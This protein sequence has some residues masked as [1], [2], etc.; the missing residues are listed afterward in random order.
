MK[1]A[2]ISIKRPV[3]ITMVT[4]ALLVFGIISYKRLPVD[5]FPNVEFP[6][7]SVFVVYPGADPETIESD[8]LKKIED[9]I[10]ILPGIKEIRSL[11]TTNFGQVIVRFELETDLN[12]AIQDIRDKIALI[13]KE[14][15]SDV[16]PPL[17]QKFDIGAEPIMTYILYG[18][19]SPEDLTEIGEKIKERLQQVEGVGDVEI[20]GKRK[21]EIQIL[22]DPEK[23]KAFGLTPLD[24]VQLIGANNIDI[25]GGHLTNESQEINIKF[26]GKVLNLEELLDIPLITVK[27]EYLGT[28]TVKLKDV[29]RVVDGIKEVRSRASYN[30]KEALALVIRK[31]SGTNAVKVAHNVIGLVKELN[32]TLPKGIELQLAINLTEF[33]EKSVHDVIFD[34]LFGAALAVIIISIFLR[35]VRATVISGLALPTSVIATFI[36]ISIM[37]FTL[38]LLVMMALSISIGMLIDDAI[39]VIENI[40]RHLEGGE[41]RKTASYKG[42]SE[43]GLAVMATTF[44]IVAVFVPVAFTKGVIG[45]FLY[46]FGLTVSFAVLV[47][48]FV[49]FTLTPMLSSR[50]LKLPSKNIITL[51]IERGLAWLDT[52]YRIIIKWSLNHRFITVSIGFLAFIIGMILL[53]NIKKDMIPKIDRSQFYIRVKTPPG[54]SLT[55]TFTLAQE[56]GKFVSQEKIVKGI[57][58]SAGSGV[59]EEQNR[60]TLL[61]NLVPKEERTISQHQFMEKIRNKLEKIKGAV[62]SVEDIGIMGESFGFTT[63]PIQYV[64]N[65]NDID[66]LEEVAFKIME[67]MKLTSGFVDVT[68]NIEK[69]QPEVMVRILRER[70]GDLNIIGAQAGQLL[71]IMIAGLVTSKYTEKGRDYDIRVGMDPKYK[72]DPY[73]LELLSIRSSKGQ[74]IDFSNI[75]QFVPSIGRSVINRF[76]RERQVT[77]FANLKGISM[78]EG[79]AKVREISKGLLPSDL[80]AK[81]VGMG[82]IMEESF[83]SLSFALLLAIIMLYMILASQFE[84]FIYPLVIMVSLPVAIIGTGFMLW[85]TNTTITVFTY[86]GIIML[87]GLVTK[88]AILLVDY[89]NQLRRQGISRNDALIRAGGIRLRPILM[90]TLAMIFGML[91]V[92]LGKGGAG[93]LKQG[94][95]IAVIG[96]LFTS[97][98]LTL[99]LVPSIYTYFDD[100]QRVILKTFGLKRINDNSA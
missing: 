83:Q 40:F 76:N 42:T 74:I 53:S 24:V 94:M 2:E 81:F 34:L 17:V 58:I 35:N 5:L 77:I 46:Q 11:A 54:S 27:N 93:E 80:R 26:K 91:P 22:L 78:E 28:A 59:L 97:M 72:R 29:A 20:I 56:I 41:E 71:R 73:L 3:F 31:Q 33:T 47:S 8:V 4:A 98:F 21:R 82:E 85:I 60:A 95:G 16:E 37:G 88:N 67:R 57:Y 25:P 52:T 13:Q 10:G 99:I 63:A 48:L 90:T 44:S 86:I 75:A 12:Q 69:G 9:A 68:S 62:L 87:M 19:M 6:L 61:V 23:L 18:N 96:G 100:F 50:M 36:F 84:S 49:S 43:I 55:K 45:R 15:P 7:G 70:A 79:M 64:I 92:A 66:K 32:S 14:F 38:N 1:L 39:V 51:M 30:G 65:G 89:T